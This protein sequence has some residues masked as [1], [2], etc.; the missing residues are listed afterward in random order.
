M[1]AQAA[2]AAT[3][4]AERIDEILNDDDE[5]D[6]DDDYSESTGRPPMFSL[7]TEPQEAGQE[8]LRSGD[9]SRVRRQL[10]SSRKDSNL[11][12][13]IHE[14]TARA[15]PHIY[16]EDYA[17]N[18]IP[19][20]VGSAVAVYG[21]NIYTGQ[22][23]KDSSFYYTCAQDFRLHIYDTT[24]PLGLVPGPRDP[25]LRTIMTVK[26]RIQASPGRWTVTDSHLSPDN[27][28]LV[29][30]SIASTAYITSTVENSP[31]QLPIP[32]ADPLRRGQSMQESF[33]IWSCR[34]SADGNEVIAGAGSVYDLLA[35]KRTVKI[36]AHRD[37]INSCCWADSASGNVL[38]SASDDSFLKVWDRRS[39]GGSN[40]PSGVLVGHTEGITNVSAKGDGRYLISNGKDQALRLWDLR[41]MRSSTEFD[42]IKNE[43]YGVRGFDYRY[44]RYP[45]LKRAA[46]PQ[47]CSVM[48]YRGHSVLRTLIRCY[49]SPAETTGS[50][51]I[52]SGSADGRIHLQLLTVCRLDGR[53]VQEI[54]RSETLPISFD[55]SAPDLDR[56]SDSQHE[57]VCVRDLSWHSQEPYLLSAAW[58]TDQGGSIVAKHEWKGLSKLSGNLE[59]WTEK[60]RQERME[61]TRYSMPGTFD[62]DDDEDEMDEDEF[63]IPSTT[64]TA[65]INHGFGEGYFLIRNVGSG[66]R[67]LDVIKDL[68]EDGTEINL[69]PETESS[70]VESRRNPN[71]NNQVFF[72]DTEGALCSRS[73]GHAVD[74]EDGQLVLR[75]R[76]PLSSPFPNS[77]SHPLPQ[78]TFSPATGEIHVVCSYPPL[79]GL[80]SDW[81]SKSYVLSAIPLRKPRTI[82]DDFL[83]TASSAISAPFALLSGQ[84]SQTTPEEVFDGN[85][86]L[87][88]EEVLQEERGEEAEVDDSAEFGR[89]VRVLA[90]S[91]AETRGLV[92]RARLRRTWQIQGLRTTDART[93]K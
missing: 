71:A 79:P 2:A 18:L 5:D 85:I 44:F 25:D 17:S 77:Y 16:K 88:E 50:Q 86:D 56:L 10:N 93:G 23:S 4:A 32:F 11:G 24:V 73:S 49:F 80:S 58:N 40:R 72:I 59:D 89:P 3:S 28:R 1:D 68:V 36:P 83:S 69:W 84:L 45:Q 21:S 81:Q 38:V 92:E 76:R 42:E 87:K 47:D 33:A 20:S 46:H 43:N 60:H 27:Q 66:G 53:I 15:R 65:H 30:S 64:T 34:F 22:F 74:I 31:V 90:T 13:L 78:F 37:D 63:M 6:D 35:N 7:V 57:N 19:N 55:P 39:L 51:Y 75:H 8:L 67:L 52:Y 61:S 29:Y 91:A 41:K 62:S 82:I 26:R 14:R 9:F 54:D 12:R 70:L 48:T